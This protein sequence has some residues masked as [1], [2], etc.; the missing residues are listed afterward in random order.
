S[1]P[2]MPP[3]MFRAA[4]VAAVAAL[5]LLAAGCGGKSKSS[6]GST[7]ASDWADG[8]CSSISTW[9]TSVQK[10]TS[11]VK[12]STTVDSLQSAT[13]DVT[14]ATNKFVDDLQALGTPDTES[15]K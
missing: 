5:A 10:A 8:L 6:S 9:S 15:G 4:C 1:V 12:G 7:S 2:S 14:K 11:S 3:G 13:G